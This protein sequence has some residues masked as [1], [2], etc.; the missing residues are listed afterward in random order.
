MTL[1]E[2]RDIS[3]S[4]GGVVAV[5]G[6]SFAIQKGQICALIGPNGAGKTT[7]FNVITGIYRPD[8]G[9]VYF[10]D[11][12]ISGFKPHQIA[13]LGITRTF[14]NLQIFENMSVR[15][16]VMVGRHV[17]TKTGLLPAALGL[18]SSRRESRE[19]RRRADDFLRQV[20]L[21]ERAN[22]SAANLPF[23]QQRLLEIARAM[24]LEPKLLLLDEPAAGL[25]GGETR[26]LEKVILRLRDQGTSILLVE[27]DME[28]VMNLADNIVVMDFGH[29]IAEGGPEKI[30]KDPQVLKAYLGEEDNNA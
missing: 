5:S 4:F 18:P 27:H 22:E 26:E 13:A 6:V 9:Q 19:C 28:T 23:G 7:L 25:P 12:R 1:L 16:N 30:Q 10:E 11:R 29:K 8:S 20:G 15:E 21:A 14:Q 17:L 3:K 2:V 24:A